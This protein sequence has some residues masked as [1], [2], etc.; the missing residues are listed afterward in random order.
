MKTRSFSLASLAL[1]GLFGCGTPAHLPEYSSAD[2]AGTL[3][4]STV[5]TAEGEAVIV[6]LEPFADKAR[7]ETYSPGQRSL[8]VGGQKA[9][10]CYEYVMKSN[11]CVKRVC[12][13]S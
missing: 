7:C 9:N 2:R 13:G 6:S 1:A 5:K 10:S 11:R 4:G 8:R 12:V 3:V